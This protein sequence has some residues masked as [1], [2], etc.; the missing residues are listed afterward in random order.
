MTECSCEAVCEVGWHYYNGNCFKV[1]TTKV[2]QS[3]ARSIGAMQCMQIWPA[4]AIK[5]RWI[6]SKE[7]RENL[8]VIYSTFD[9]GLLCRCSQQVLCKRCQWWESRRG[10]P[11]CQAYISD[12]SAGYRDVRQYSSAS[13]SVPAGVD[14]RARMSSFARNCVD[15]PVLMYMCWSHNFACGVS[16]SHFCFFVIDS[17][18]VAWNNWFWI[19]TGLT[20]AI[21]K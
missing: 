12:V 14:D 19:T 16:A 1:S 15:I 5:L 13:T 9:I 18:S 11:E 2:S 20:A 21:S 3:T 17:I 8:H 7:S 6:S 4:S 10:I